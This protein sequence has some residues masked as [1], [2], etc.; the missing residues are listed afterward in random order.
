[1]QILAIIGHPRIKLSSETETRI[2]LSEYLAIITKKTDG[3]V[4]LVGE[5]QMGFRNG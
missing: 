3:K 5:L 2:I 1:M 4:F